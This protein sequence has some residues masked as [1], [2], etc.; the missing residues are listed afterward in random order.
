MELAVSGSDLWVPPP[1]RLALTTEE[2][3]VW[4]VGLQQQ[5]WTIGMFLEALSADERVRANKYHFYRDFESFVIARGVLRNIISRY[6][7]VASRDIRFSYDQYG[8]PRLS[9]GDTSLCFSVSHSSGIA[10]YAISQVDAVGVD[11]EYARE[12]FSSTEIAEHFFSANEV[13]TLRALPAELRTV[14]FFNCWTRKEAYIKAR[15]EGLSHPL[16]RFTVSIIPGQPARLLAADDTKDTSCWTLMEL[17]AGADY[18]ASLAV[19]GKVRS[20][21]QWQWDDNTSVNSTPG[22]R[23]GSDVTTTV[24]EDAAMDLARNVR[25]T[26]RERKNE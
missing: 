13:A 4:R 15:G 12:N 10:L 11:I 1:E 23:S 7:N 25:R 24:L 9:S 21:R 26:Q 20:L 16:N 19:E 17:S 3:H 2:V 14:A 8:K 18:V 22:V 6:I 5:P